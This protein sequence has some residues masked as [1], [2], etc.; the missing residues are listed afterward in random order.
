M[1]QEIISGVH[2]TRAEMLQLRRR[3]ILA[4]R[5]HDLLEEKKDALLLHFFE[6][7]KNIGTLREDLLKNLEKSYKE[8]MLA[9]MNLGPERLREL[10]YSVPDRFNIKEGSRNIIGVQIPILELQTTKYDTPWYNIYET[11]AT[12]DSAVKSMES[13]LEMIIEL[14]EVESSIKRL[15]EVITV[16]KRRVNALEN[17]IIPR[18]ENTIKYIRMHLEER[19]REDFF[20]LKRIKTIHTGKKST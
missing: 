18:L 20:R 7:I 19:A 10:S 9:E 16:T 14:A 17:I 13:S 4:R 12:L 1:A 2:A 5:G 8:L 6:M 3:A 15:V 11:S